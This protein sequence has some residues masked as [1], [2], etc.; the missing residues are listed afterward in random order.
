[1]IRLTGYV[2]VQKSASANART[3]DLGLLQPRMNTLSDG[4]GQ[5][6]LMRRVRQN[7]LP[8][9]LSAHLTIACFRRFVDWLITAHIAVL[10]TIGNSGRALSHRGTRL[11]KVVT[12]RLSTS[13]SAR[14]IGPP[15]L[16]FHRQCCYRNTRLHYDR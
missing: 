1:M 15:A 8:V 13:I 14:R 7:A 5:N 12:I 4:S 16:L 3:P 9:A 6:P 11:T 2:G 10:S